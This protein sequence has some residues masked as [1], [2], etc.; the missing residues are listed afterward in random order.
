MDSLPVHIAVLTIADDAAN[1]DRATSRAID[2][3]AKAAGHH[4]V[5]EEVVKDS[6][7]AIRNQLVRW[8]AEPNIDVVI[9]VATLE[10]QAASAALAPLVMQTLPGFTDLFRWLTF[11]EI[12]ASAMQSTAEAAQ[13]E[14]TFVFVLP[15]HPAAVTAAMDKL[16]LPQLDART[17]PKNLVTQMPRLKDAAKRFHAEAKSQPVAAPPSKPA[18][19][20]PATDADIVTAPYATLPAIDPVTAPVEAVPTVISSEK[21]E[22]GSGLMAKLPAK[23]KTTANTIARKQD[24]PPTKQIDLANLEKQ[25]A[26]SGA[27][28][29]TKEVLALTANDAKTKIVDMSAHQAKTRVVDPSRLP[30]VP[31]GADEL[32]DD[33]IEPLTFVSPNGPAPSGQA[34]P[35]RSSAPIGVVKAPSVHTAATPPFATP[36]ARSTPP[37]GRQ[38]VSTP[39]VSTPVV[40]R[41]TPP[42]GRQAISTP[43]VSTPVV[44]RQTPLGTPAPT[45]PPATVKPAAAGA[46]K[47]S[48]TEL[49]RRHSANRR[50]DPVVA[51]SMVSRSAAAAAQAPAPAPI[52]KPAAP[53]KPV[54]PAAAVEPPTAAA[55]AAAVEPPAAEPPR[56]PTPVPNAAE[57][58]AQSVTSHPASVA[59]TTDA[60]SSE[61][62]KAESDESTIST[63]F[64]NQPVR[65]RPPTPPPAH[66]DTLAK[67]IG[68]GELPQGDFVYPIKRSGMPLLLKIVLA[69]ALL[70][71][72]FFAF[73]KFYPLTDKPTQIA[74][75]PPSEPAPTPAPAV[76]PPPAAEPPPAV[77]EPTGSD[78]ADIEIDTTAPSQPTR[79]TRPDKPVVKPSGETKPSGE[80]KP[81][82]ETKPSGGAVTKPTHDPVTKPHDTTAATEPEPAPADDG[83]D[84]VSCVLAKYDRPCCEKYRP[85]DG[86]TPKN[87]I[88]DEL[89]K[90]MVKAGIEKVKPRVVACGEKGGIKGTVKVAMT[91]D[92][93]GNV[94]TASVTESPD[95]ALGNCVAAALKNA[96]FG[97]T[98]NGGEFTYPFVF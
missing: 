31:P 21:T 92:A 75:A 76:E 2:E 4:V 64:A 15:A 69:L 5:D 46:A 30:R 48:R 81:S 68:G 44:G 91:V 79:P 1:A 66:L 43:P 56:R 70:G 25:I 6:E 32:T 38:A 9:V 72:G 86:F 50:R 47:R 85:V 53:P 42:T 22:A 67:Q 29:Q 96:K 77:A 19:I 78:T 35:V 34:S 16:I 71:A 82:G 55:P 40:G 7:E 36:V 60:K 49:R 37:T 52:E 13:C 33:D 20:K 98:V 84:E 65:K 45:K 93:E 27:G 12:G 61:P 17:T 14:S 51:R 63:L 97:K 26:M 3:R 94:K 74:A 10:S 62:P 87:T 11:Q 8:I 23:P 83:C 59:A 88:P 95:Q 73:V 39:P 41:P 90:S 24:D 58:W 80:S 28:E 18:T 89:D 54:E 57:L